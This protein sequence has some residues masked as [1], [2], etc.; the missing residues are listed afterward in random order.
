MEL[1]ES[2][3]SE[4]LEELLE[5]LEL[6]RRRLRLNLNKIVFRAFAITESE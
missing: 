4:L 6:Y 1:S 3:L 5:E 2:E